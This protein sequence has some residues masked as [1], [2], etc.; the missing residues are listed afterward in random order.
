MPAAAN[1]SASPTFAQ[2]MPTAPRSICIFATMGDLCVFACGRRR[3]PALDASPCTRAM[4]FSRRER[5]T[6]TCGVGRS[7]SVGTL[8]ALLGSCELVGVPAR[9]A[10]ELGRKISA[11]LVVLTRLVEISSLR[12]RHEKVVLRVVVHHQNAFAK[13][14]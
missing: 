12:V 3:I 5:S 4:L 14:T 8:L 6:T 7:W 13:R 1:T 11:G 10:G 2:Q 9:V